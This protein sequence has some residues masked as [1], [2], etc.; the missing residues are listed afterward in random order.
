MKK[1]IL[2][3]VIVL[4]LGVAS[5]ALAITNPAVNTTQIYAVKAESLSI[6]ASTIPNF[7]IDALG[8][9]SV[10]NQDLTITTNWNL[11]STRTA[12]AVCAGM[13]SAGMAG[14]GTNT[15]VIP[16]SNVQASTSTTFAA[17]NTAAACGTSSLVTAV[18]TNTLTAATGGL[19]RKNGTKV[20]TLHLSLTGVD[21]ALQADTYTGTITVYAFVT[22]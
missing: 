20:D 16:V 14:T 8:T 18:S 7:A 1:S 22:P 6:V 5:S 21:S 4:M 3:V 10:A 15:D 13:S 17:I 2:F 11:V 12:V 9:G 19:G